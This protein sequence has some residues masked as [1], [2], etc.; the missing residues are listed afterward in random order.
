M[1]RH[2]AAL[3]AAAV[4]LDDHLYHD[5]VGGRRRYDIYRAVRSSRYGAAKS[6]L[7]G[8]R[9]ATRRQ[10]GGRRSAS[11]RLSQQ[12]KILD[13]RYGSARKALPSGPNCEESSG[14]TWL[15]GVCAH[16]CGPGRR[17]AIALVT[18]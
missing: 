11:P 13:G 17:R 6:I 18:H 3:V 10:R 7:L 15:K 16:Y 1:S 2:R 12:K 14:P 8:L 9:E 5:G 4:G